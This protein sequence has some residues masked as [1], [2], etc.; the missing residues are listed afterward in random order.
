[1]SNNHFIV[2]F[3]MTIIWMT[4]K[5]MFIVNANAIKMLLSC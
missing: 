4:K 3:L 1:M 5:S 2:V